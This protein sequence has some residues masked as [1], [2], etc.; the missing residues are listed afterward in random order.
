MPLPKHL[1][2]HKSENLISV[3]VY[4]GRGPGGIAKGDVG[5]YM[6]EAPLDLIVNLEG[7]WKFKTGDN[8]TW[9]KINFDDSG[10]DRIPVPSL[11]DLHGY[12]KYDGFAWYRITFNLNP[13]D[14]NIEDNLILL[15]GKIDDLDETFL[16]GKFVGSTGD[17][18]ISPIDGSINGKDNKDYNKFRGYRIKRDDLRNG[19][20]VI[21][22]RVYDGILNGGIYEGPVGIASLKEYLRYRTK[23]MDNDKKSFIELLFDK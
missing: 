11:W 9:S 5:I 7:S 21:A 1:L 23:D 6:S 3:R 22:V 12:D 16:N 18:I 20:N 19:K 14:T 2:N 8:S 4:D 15:L 17:L 13:D 10:W